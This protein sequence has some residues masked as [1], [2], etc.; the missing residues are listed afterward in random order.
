MRVCVIVCIYVLHIIFR[1]KH[2]TCDQFYPYLHVF[3]K[4]FKSELSIHRQ[5]YRINY[6]LNIVIEH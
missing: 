3:I 4:S 2:Q 6:K 5:V 1:E